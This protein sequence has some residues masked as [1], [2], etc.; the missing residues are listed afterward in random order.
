MRITWAQKVAK[1]RARITCIPIIDNNMKNTS[2]SN[3]SILISKLH[4]TTQD[5][6]FYQIPVMTTKAKKFQKQKLCNNTFLDDN[7]R[8]VHQND[9][10][11]PNV[12]LTRTNDRIWVHC[13]KDMDIL[14]NKIKETCLI[15]NP[16]QILNI[17]DFEL[18][19]E[20]TSSKIYAH[21]ITKSWND[22]LNNVMKSET[23]IPGRPDL[24]TTP[25]EETNISS[26]GNLFTFQDGR[27]HT[28]RIAISRTTI[29]IVNTQLKL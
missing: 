5:R 2:S 17:T 29:T 8:A 4:K 28:V 24:I 16:I 7:I 9:Y 22:Q 12:I 3:T 13:T 20:N 23:D 26:I 11:I 21:T 25:P 6:C 27:P 18:Q 15:Q 10:D 14:L 1:N 19:G